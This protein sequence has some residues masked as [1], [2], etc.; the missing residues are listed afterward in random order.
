M[1]FQLN[2]VT[3]DLGGKWTANFSQAAIGRQP[4][5]SVMVC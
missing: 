3:G 2:E 1:R 4:E 5:T